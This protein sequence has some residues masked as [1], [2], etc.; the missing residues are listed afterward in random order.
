MALLDG[1]QIK[2]GS[3]TNAKLATPA[4]TPTKN[5]KFITC[6][7]TV[8]DFDAATASGITATPASD[9]FVEVMVN[10][11]MQHLGDGV[12]TTDCFFSA[13]GGTTAKTIANIAA[14]D[15]LYWVGTVAGF[16]LAVT[17]K[18]SYNYSV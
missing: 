9:G 5:D 12:K 14:A 17:D 15:I 18:L 4:G 13:D 6:L 11:A 16:Q 8:A 10:G 7:A 3:I 1:K 2:D